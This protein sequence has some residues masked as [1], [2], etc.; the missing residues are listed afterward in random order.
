MV[1]TDFDKTNI[2]VLIV[3]F[4]SNSRAMETL[5][6]MVLRDGSRLGKSNLIVVLDKKIS[7]LFKKDLRKNLS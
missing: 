1:V 7:H 3:I 5:L 6:N 4:N 2:V